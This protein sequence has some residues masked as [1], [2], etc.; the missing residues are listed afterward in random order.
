[1]KPLAGKDSWEVLGELA[2]KLGCSC[3]SDEINFEAVAQAVQK[4]YEKA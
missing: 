1:V 2:S 4:I 3:S